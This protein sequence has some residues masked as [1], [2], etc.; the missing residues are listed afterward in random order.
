MNSYETSADLNYIPTPEQEG[1][2]FVLLPDGCYPARC[3]DAVAKDARSGRPIIEWTLRIPAAVTSGMGD[4][5]LRHNTNTP[6]RDD[7]NYFAYFQ[8]AKALGL[9]PNALPLIQ[10][11]AASKDRAIGVNLRQKLGTWVDQ[12]GNDQSAL[13]SEVE[14][15][16][17]W[18]AVPV[19][20]LARLKAGQTRTEAPPQVAAPVVAAA[21][22]N[23]SAYDF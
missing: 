12:N 18:T 16:V 8:M 22:A 6:R 17:P 14:R 15:T 11:L 13:R 4:Q 21:P 20:M 7:G 3:I 2:T 23:G 10:V 1:S 5:I 9:D 19:D